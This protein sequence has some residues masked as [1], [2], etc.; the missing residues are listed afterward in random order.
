[1]I[2]IA[3]NDIERQERLEKEFEEAK[4]KFS[5]IGRKYKKY[6]KIWFIRNHYI[7]QIDPQSK[8]INRIFQELR[9]VTRKNH[10]ERFIQSG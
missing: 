1:M 10:P 3:E 6:N 5:D 7:M 2:T 9:K 8:V 4:Q